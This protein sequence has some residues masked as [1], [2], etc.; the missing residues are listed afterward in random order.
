[1][2]NVSSE[3]ELLELRNEGKISEQEYE[4]LLET[5]RKTTK[6]D[7]GPALQEKSGPVR[8]SGL[9][10]ASLVFSLLGPVCSIPAVICG[11]IA[12]R[13]IR[14]EASVKGFGLALAGLLIGYA[15]LAFSIF[16]FTPLLLLYDMR[17]DL[18][19]DFALVELQ[20]TKKEIATSELK[21]YSLDSTE[22]VLTQS[23]VT[24]DRQ[25]SSDGSGSLRINAA[26]PTTVRLFETGDVDIEN[27]RLVYQ[28]QLRTA[29]VEG[30]VYLEM[31]CS[32]PG[33]GEFFSRDLATPLRG[34]TEWSTEQTP[35]ILKAG[36]NPD[37]VKLNLV[38][39]GKGTVWIDDIRLIK[40]A[41]N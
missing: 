14:K 16:V 13:K 1:M 19:E 10:I 20:H 24:I 31:W 30:Q 32:F 6:A 3:E 29:N 8:T 22:G 27:A 11:H 17:A 2:E 15:V 18:G 4:E 40:G 23:G 38:I 26:E 39:N 34:T 12:L 9:A 35:F 37:N 7:V 28:A 21:Q 36:E 5:L 41:L 25:I 33:R